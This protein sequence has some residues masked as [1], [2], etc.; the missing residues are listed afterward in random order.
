MIIT[1]ELTEPLLTKI[2]KNQSTENR[3]A[4]FGCIERQAVLPLSFKM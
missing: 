2:K 4:V 1:S 3:E